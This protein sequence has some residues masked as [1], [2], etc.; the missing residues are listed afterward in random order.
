MRIP[1]TLKIGGHIYTVEVVDRL[2]SGINYVGEIDYNNNKISIS[3]N[4]D[5]N[6]QHQ[7]FLHEVIH[8]IYN[9]LGYTDHDEKQ[10]DELA[11]ALYQLIVDNPKLFEMTDD[12]D[13]EDTES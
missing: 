3:K 11:H 5:V 4:Q 8:G 12:T 6:R 9:N 13:N 10:V 1:K 7:T 2:V